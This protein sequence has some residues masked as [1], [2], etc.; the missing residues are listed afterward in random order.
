M[1]RGDQILSPIC[2]N[3]ITGWQD[4]KSLKDCATF[5]KEEGAMFLTHR[6]STKFC[7]CCGN[8]PVFEERAYTYNM[9]VYKLVHAGM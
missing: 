4:G 1:L 9:N 5:C 8:P 3:K 6:S 2:L 7:A